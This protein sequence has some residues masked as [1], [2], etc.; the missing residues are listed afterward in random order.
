MKTKFLYLVTRSFCVLLVPALVGG[1]GGKA[2]GSD[3]D[4]G[5]SAPEPSAGLTGSSVGTSSDSIPTADATGSSLDPNTGLTSSG[6]T[7]ALA[8]SDLDSWDATS[9]GV[10]ETSRS[11]ETSGPDSLSAATSGFEAE[12]S[13]GQS[14]PA[15]SAVASSAS[16]S[17]DTSGASL[18]DEDSS[19][20]ATWSGE[21]SGDSVT[22]E[23]ETSASAPI[24]WL[25]PPGGRAP[26]DLPEEY[27]ALDWFDLRYGFENTTYDDTQCSAVYDDG[28]EDFG[29]IECQAGAGEWQCQCYD[30]PG[31]FEFIGIPSYFVDTSENTGEA[32]RLGAAVCL[33]ELPLL[34]RSCYETGYWG[35]SS[36]R[37]CYVEERC[38]YQH[39]SPHGA[40][41][42]SALMPGIECSEYVMYPY[43]V[44]SQYACREHG[45]TVTLIGMLHAQPER[46]LSQ[47]CG[48]GVQLFRNGVDP[49]SEG[50]VTCRPQ[51]PTVTVYNGAEQAC[52]ATYSCSRQATVLGETVELRYAPGAVRCSTSGQ[53]WNCQCDGEG[54][55]SRWSGIDGRTAC[56]QALDECMARVSP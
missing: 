1:C 56:T 34:N 11:T 5:S 53:Q 6:S 26:F 51:L 33:T 29:V 37:G 17:A 23:G 27:S 8:S 10:G 43:T 31:T 2:G 20:H 24:D 42:K 38:V 54:P 9:I 14:S 15:T 55:S 45:S 28:Q 18:T 41:T 7:T 52:D 30:R 19:G 44:E 35:G 32:C 13:E 48:V 12:T 46:T 4:P 49:D 47:T 40:L 50:P 36:P 39:V 3:P 22:G 21:T 16:L 25:Y